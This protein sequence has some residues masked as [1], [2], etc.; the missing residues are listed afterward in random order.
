MADK[1]R[2]ISIH[3][4]LAFLI[5]AF[6]CGTLSANSSIEKISTETDLPE[7]AVNCIVQ[8]KAGFI[9]IG[10][11]K[12]LYRYDGYNTINFSTINQEFNAIKIAELLI[13]GNN[14]W[15]G[16]FVS[17]MYKIDLLTYKI[18]RYH[19]KAETC[20]RTTDNNIIAISA[21]PNNSILFGSENGGLTITNPDGC[22]E[23][24]FTTN[25]ENS[26]FNNNQISKLCQIDED[27][28]LIGNSGLLI[29][30][31]KNRSFEKIENQYLQNYIMDIVKVDDNQFLV[32]TLDRL[33]L[34][35]LKNN[36]Q[37]V[38]VILE[39]KINAIVKHENIFYLAGSNGILLYD[40]FNGKLSEFNDNE[41]ISNKQLVINCFLTTHDNAL[42][43]GSESGLYTISNR[44]QQFL[45]IDSH[46]ETQSTN[47]VS[48]IE[49]WE[50]SMIIGTWGNGLY[51]LNHKTHQLEA[52]KFSNY[53]QNPPRFIY[54]TKT[55]N[56]NFWFSDKNEMGIFKIETNKEP[57]RLQHYLN[58]NG[59][60]NES[61]YYTITCISGSD[62]NSF[63]VGT[64][65][66]LLFSYNEF[67]NSFEII[68]DQN[69]QLPASKDISIFSILKDNQGFTWLAL[70]GGG[71]IKM[72]IVNNII[73]SQEIITVNNGLANNFT[74]TLFQ[75]KNQKIWIGT[76]AGLSVY[77][78]GQIE[79]LYHNNIILDIQSIAE[80]PIGFLWL[81]T[82]N[83]IY[84]IN[85]NNH[86]EAFKNFDTSDGLINKS[87]FLNSIYADSNQVFY[88]G[89]YNGIDYFTPYK[90]EFNY[91]KPAP[92]ITNF[93]ILNRNIFPN[94]ASDQ[95]ILRKTITETSEIELK[96]NQNS[97]SFEFS[98]LEYLNQ[99]KC[100][101][102]FKLEG[103]DNEWNYRDSKQRYAYYTKLSPGNYTFHLK[104]TNNDGLWS[105]ETLSL[106]I[107]ILPPFWASTFAYII[108]FITAMLTI[109]LVIYNRVM[110]MQ[111]N[112]QQ[113]LKEIEY[114]KQKELDELKL[115]FFT[116]I[117]HEFRTPLT[118]ILGPLSKLLE[119]EKN[120]P[121]KEAHLMI[122][123][124]AGRLLQLT[125][126]ILDFRKNENE[127][128]KLKVSETNVSDFVYNIF[129]FFNYEA[130]KRD[131]DYRF[132]TNFD[133]KQL[134]D[135]EFIESVC[136]NLLS[137]AFK[138][139]PDGKSI[140]VGVDPHNDGISIWVADTGPGIEPQN[141]Q[142]IFDR[143]YTTNKQN[144]AGIGLSFSK[145]LI[146]LHKGELK[147]E[148][149]YGH[150]SKFTVVLP[151]DSVYSNE[152][153]QTAD[154][155][156]QTVDWKKID[157]TVQK[158]HTEQINNLKSI[159]DKDEMVALIVD[160]NFEVRQFL[161][162]LLNENFKVIEASNGEQALEIAFNNI[163]DIVISDVMMPGIDGYQLCQKL[164]NDER[165]DHI[166]VILT[167]VLSS[168]DDRNEGLLKGADS[169]IPKPI[170]PE[171]LLIRVN[172]L[173]EKQLK[174]K[175]KFKISNFSAAN[176]NKETNKSDVHPLVEKAHKIVLKNIDNSEYNIDDFCNDLGLSRMQL[177]RK[178]KAITGLSANSFI[179]KVRLHK[180]AELLKTGN[181]TVKEVTY[182]VGFI[183]LKYFR[184]CFYDEFGAN[185]SDYAQ[186]GKSI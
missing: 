135:R 146:E 134:I 53:K 110:K 175:E 167:T 68:K 43:A 165:T 44:K 150:G 76:E 62:N 65:D 89:G 129:L 132:K 80:D 15:V 112:H 98:N 166:P 114:K 124:N 99:E 88:F 27:R 36:A 59:I 25:S 83:G 81:G 141:L 152:Q 4:M 169:Y 72:K 6:A 118:L 67:K 148:S 79:N 10:T 186:S 82:P 47:I 154:S 91:Q 177:Y 73:L 95:T 108:Y 92:K 2:S 147:V 52:L 13:D 29:F 97:F 38:K 155:K 101:F 170:D 1:I 162:S 20:Q 178:F 77:N 138:Y 136:F 163:P 157:Q 121:Y 74:T 33:L 130:Q 93:Q 11:W 109:F 7:G 54:A 144:S 50:N 179:R 182:D 66:G 12:G 115:R 64:W 137:N 22:I 48:C 21:M 46:T 26:K 19:Q 41:T 106:S 55:I 127:Q 122:F 42:I 142:H 102:A 181:Y 78:N 37:Q 90:I 61:G 69:G 17:G 107:N 156:E 35:D 116:N 28:I 32:S 100:Q 40:A 105:D 63:I 45:H 60:E 159:F 51:K 58:F 168:Q 126:R 24:N 30:N 119:T 75:S 184:K 104:S 120:N 160:D 149:E 23:E 151:S 161:T 103:V 49:T 176:E 70:S 31:L 153:K 8:D 183:D 133:Q 9:W 173:I 172:K 96:H 113:K 164:K 18:T 185:P 111:H 86:N 39:Q 131:I 174:L 171:H 71:V 16:T 180:A 57:Y 143:F 145:R 140:T 125:N 87:F 139:T 94:N 3:C 56:N 128:L 85:S 158:Q 117:S 84:R 14:L 34:V 123:R 5:I